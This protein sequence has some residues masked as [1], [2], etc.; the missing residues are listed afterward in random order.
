MALSHILQQKSRFPE[1]RAGAAWGLSRN[2]SATLELADKMFGTIGVRL[3]P[4]V[5]EHPQVERHAS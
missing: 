5:S 4:L 2:T 1:C 3:P